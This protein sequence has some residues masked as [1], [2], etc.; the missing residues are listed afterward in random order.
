MT[1]PNQKKLQSSLQ[2]SAEHS[3][4]QVADQ[5]EMFKKVEVQALTPYKRNLE[6]K[7]IGPYTVIVANQDLKTAKYK[8]R[9]ENSRTFS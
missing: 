8:I 3:F 2:A 9:M 4:K 1:F 7:K 5:T 6:S